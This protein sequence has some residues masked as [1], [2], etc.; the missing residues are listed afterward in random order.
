[1]LTKS[2]S[3]FLKPIF[4]AFCLVGSFTFLS[5]EGISPQI[6]N[7]YL[8]IN[9]KPTQELVSLLEAELI[10]HDGTL[11]GIVEATQKRWVRAKDKERWEIS[12][13]STDHAEVIFPILSSLGLFDE[14][15]PANKQFD[16]AV[17]FGATLPTLRQRFAFLIKKWNEGIRF[18]SLVFLCSYRP[19][20]SPQE[21]HFNLCDRNNG[22]L[23]FQLN[24][25]PNRSF[26]ETEVEMAQFV[27]DQSEFPADMLQLPVTFVAAPHHQN[28]DGSVRRANTEDTLI[29]W[30]MSKP[31][32]KTFIFISNQ[33]FLGYQASIARRLLPKTAEME[34]AGDGYRRPVAISICLDALAWWLYEISSS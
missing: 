18:Q 7:E 20:N 13:P 6:L 12:D 19:L 31:G 5:I 32:G 4:F 28:P 24:W 30:M 21:T 16:C 29:H 9:Q 17:I 3:L 23:P 25:D 27:Y 8:V 26:P 14:I 1:M 34:I 33:P 15:N 10:S 2:N 22:I 11:L